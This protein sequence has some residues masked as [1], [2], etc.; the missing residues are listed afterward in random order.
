MAKDKGK[1]GKRL[2]GTK[3][4]DKPAANGKCDILSL[5]RN[6]ILLFLLEF[7][8]VAVVFLAV[9]YYVGEFYQSAIFF[10]GRPILLA[11]GCPPLLLGSCFSHI[12][13]EGGYLVNFNLVPFVALAIATPELM[14]RKRLEMLAIGVPV[15]FLLHLL[16]LMAHFPADIYDSALAEMVVYSIGVSDV[17]VPFIIW[18]AIAVS[19]RSAKKVIA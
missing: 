4:V 12:A 1:K 6:Q 5:S 15:L 11:M 10:F 8:V 18:F 9:W 3:K 17:A 7:L 2:T 16:D 19:F 13:Q 14:L